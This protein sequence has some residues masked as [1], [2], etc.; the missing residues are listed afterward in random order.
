M[1]FSKYQFAALIVYLALS[2]W[3]LPASAQ[4]AKTV[5]LYDSGSR[6]FKPL[7]SIAMSSPTMWTRIPASETTHEFSG[8][9]IV[10]NAPIAMVIRH[11]GK[12]AEIYHK[13]LSGWFNHAVLMAKGEQP[14]RSVTEFKIVQN[15][16]DKVTVEVTYKTLNGG[17]ITVRFSSEAGAATV[18]TSP[19][20]GT[21]KLVVEAPARFVVLPSSSGE[22]L[23]IDATEVS[24]GEQE[25]S[26]ESTVLHM[27]EHGD[28]IVMSH[29]T[30][31][32]SDVLENVSGV[33]AERQII[34]SEI[35]LED[36]SV[37]TS[38]FSLSGAW[39]E[40]HVDDGAGG[41]ELRLLWRWPRPVPWMENNGDATSK[42]AEF[43]ASSEFA[44]GGGG[45][46][47]ALVYDTGSAAHAPLA[48]EDMANYRAWEEVAEEDTSHAFLGDAVVLNDKIA[49][50]V[51]QTG[52]GIELY[53][54]QGN[55]FSPQAVMRVLG[56]SKVVRLS[57]ISLGNNAHDSVAIA[58]TY[59]TESGGSA[60]IR[61]E[62]NMGQ[63]S[64]KTN[65]LASTK[66]LHI[67]APGR[68]A[69]LPDF[70]ADDI[71]I[72][73]WDISSDTAELPT[74]NFLMHMT[75]D[76]NAIVL[77]VWD[78]NDQDVQA[79]L[80]GVSH[81]RMID[82]SEYTYGDKGAVWVAVLCDTGIWH[83]HDIGLQDRDKVIPLNWR[84]PFPALWRVDWSRSDHMTDSWEMLT[85]VA[86]GEFK[87]HD[88]FKENEDSWTIQDW[89]GSGERTR[90][91]PG[92]GRFKYPCWVSM[93]GQG[94]LQ[95]LKE[96]VEFEGP[97]IIYP[98]NR[99]AA[100]PLD[101]YT[102][103]DVVRGSLGVGP[104]EYIL[105]VEG[106]QVVAAG[107][108][109]CTV[110]D[111]LN[112]IYEKNEQKDQ[113]AEVEQALKNVV[114][115]ISL[116]RHRID[117]YGAFATDMETYLKQA[118]TQYPQHAE[119]L[120]NMIS[121]TKQIEEAIDKRRD[122]IKSIE[123]AKQLTDDFRQ[124]VLNDTSAGAVENCKK[125]TSQ[126]VEIGGNQD[127]LVAECRLIVR[128]LR[129]RAGTALAQDPSL[130]PIANEIRERTQE[131]LRA[132]VNYEAARH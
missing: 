104:C 61:C 94:F 76:G 27:L 105:D 63:V 32:G 101:K 71:V 119:F 29:W 122:D 89:W 92:L 59:A 12:G 25:A 8:D 81:Q 3:A 80:S 45:A 90:I 19:V 84:V 91:T 69:I 102:L 130:E 4:K 125:Y 120:D 100:T 48:P 98:L 129:Q 51:R 117:A 73:A 106:Q 26:G 107:W 11:D 14:A 55:E 116:I 62:L 30:G 42:L 85:E 34:S 47:F 15:S 74:E 10:M 46:P 56:D 65:A 18:E 103:V 131:I 118:K 78:N 5:A 110:R 57:D 33:D 17:D 121:V 67:H 7:T 82:S 60:G 123:F 79:N 44:P 111:V 23:L 53:G 96:S 70:F 1:R 128:V 88:L 95:P 115:F 24:G 22:G 68:F 9:V 43:E 112:E 132:P 72:D 21:A 126:W 124:E 16:E 2:M 52:T 109:T 28:V 50:V 97:A 39:G 75:D 86:A 83:E 58:V 40:R 64:V 37:S 54:R 13:T 87:K 93:N 49:A 127:E 113:R 35:P 41:T 6:S 108:P 38:I 114:D 36:G 77:T 66:K 99:L 20:K 31:T